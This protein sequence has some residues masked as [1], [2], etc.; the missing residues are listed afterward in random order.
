MNIELL[1]QRLQERER[2]LVL[3]IAHLQ[4]EARVAGEAAASQ[5]ASEFL[6]EEALATRTLTQVREASQRIAQATYGKC[7]TCGRPIEEARLEAIHWATD[8]LKDQ[9]L[10]DREEH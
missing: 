6:Q 10:K 2:D 7:V 9:G 3:D 8:C 5:G 4:G 1:I